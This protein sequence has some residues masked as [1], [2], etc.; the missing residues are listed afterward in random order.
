MAVR[1]FAIG[2]AN[3]LKVCDVFQTPEERY[4]IGELIISMFQRIQEASVIPRI[5]NF[6]TVEKM[7]ELQ[8]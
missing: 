7:P 3:I 2:I 4:D 1:C 8:V 5:I 6:L